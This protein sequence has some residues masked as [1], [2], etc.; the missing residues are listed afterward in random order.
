[1]Y[2]IYSFH[3]IFRGKGICS[4]HRLSVFMT[5]RVIHSKGYPQ[6]KS[7]YKREGTDKRTGHTE[8][9]VAADQ[10]YDDDSDEEEIAFL[11]RSKNRSSWPENT[12]RPS[13]K[14]IERGREEEKKDM[15]RKKRGG[16]KMNSLLS[17]T[18]VPVTLQVHLF[19]LLGS[20]CL[21]CKTR[22]IPRCNHH[23]GCVITERNK[24]IE[25]ESER[26]AMKLV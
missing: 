24:E 5:F 3:T 19:S 2:L 7:S 1:M 8:H 15:Q 4:H 14:E 9:T 13:K 17:E 21:P 6:V 18:S 20:V 10:G 26:I 22:V 11:C 23:Q 25:Q 16:K 12:A